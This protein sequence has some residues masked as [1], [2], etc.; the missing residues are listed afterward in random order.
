MQ[1]KSDFVRLQVLLD[2]GGMY[3]DLDAI[4]LKS[5]DKLRKA[6]YD[7]VFARQKYGN[8]AVGLMMTKKNNSLMKE[9]LDE[10]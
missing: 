6:G 7:C 9:F 8:T 5:F 3:L 2:Y 1:H 4:P 10:G